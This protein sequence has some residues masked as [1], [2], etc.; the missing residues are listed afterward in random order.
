M[1]RAFSRHV[2]PKKCVTCGKLT[3]YEI[4]D[5]G[6]HCKDCWDLAGMENEHLDGYHKAGDEDECPLCHPEKYPHW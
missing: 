1:K 4:N 6:A 2:Q 3:T 5:V